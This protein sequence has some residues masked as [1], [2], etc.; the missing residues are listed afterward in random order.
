MWLLLAI[1]CQ[2]LFAQASPCVAFN[3][4]MPMQV[5]SALC[6]AALPAPM[7]MAHNQQIATR[8]QQHDMNMVAE[9]VQCAAEEKVQRT[10][11]EKAQLPAHEKVLHHD[12]DCCKSPNHCS[13]GGCAFI[14]ANT[15]VFVISAPLARAVFTEVAQRLP[16]FISQSLYRPPI[17]A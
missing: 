3:S 16:A 11:E 15:G 17:V 6:Q 2:S 9:K 13:V 7:H 8:E 14:Q 4:T 1:F 10:A 5:L 12:K